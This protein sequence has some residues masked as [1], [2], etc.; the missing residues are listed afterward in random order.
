MKVSERF[1]VLILRACYVHKPPDKCD[2]SLMEM[3]MANHIQF[4][5]RH[6]LSLSLSLFWK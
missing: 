1:C 6:V 2:W 5:N 4:L 3:E